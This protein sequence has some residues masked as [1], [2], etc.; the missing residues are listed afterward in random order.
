M[1]PLHWSIAKL[2]IWFVL[3]RWGKNQYKG[4]GDK[5]SIVES[6]YQAKSPKFCQECV[7]GSFRASSLED[8]YKLVSVFYHYIF[9]T[10]GL[11]TKTSTKQWGEFQSKW[12]TARGKICH[13][14]VSNGKRCIRHLDPQ[15][16]PLPSRCFTIG[17]WKP[18]LNM[19]ENER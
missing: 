5:I 1:C 8:H 13:D 4:K 9:W 14:P 7:L 15:I 18:F 10:K 6:G 12:K 19:L 2:S 16:R 11:K 3:G 17:I